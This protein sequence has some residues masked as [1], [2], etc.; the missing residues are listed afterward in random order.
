MPPAASSKSATPVTHPSPSSTTPSTQQPSTLSPT[1][2]P[3]INYHYEKNNA[4]GGI[5]SDKEQLVKSG[6]RLSPQDTMQA[7]ATMGRTHKSNFSVASLLGAHPDSNNPKL[8]SKPHLPDPGSRTSSEGV[9]AGRLNSTQGPH[10]LLSVGG[11]GGAGVGLG[12]LKTLEPSGPTVGLRNSPS[13]ISLKLKMPKFR[14]FG[15]SRISQNARPS[16]SPGPQSPLSIGSP[17]LDARTRLSDDTL[18]LGAME[19]ENN[20]PLSSYLTPNQPPK[21][22]EGTSA[23]W[24]SPPF[25]SASSISQDGSM[26]ETPNTRRSGLFRPGSPGL[27]E[28]AAS[29][30][31]ELNLKYNAFLCDDVPSSV[32]RSAEFLKSRARSF[33]T[34]TQDDM[35]LN[36]QS[37][38]QKRKSLNRTGRRASIST[39]STLLS[40]PIPSHCPDSSSRSDG[41]NNHSRRSLIENAATP[42][43]FGYTR[44]EEPVSPWSPL[45]SRSV[46]DDTA[47][48]P[49]AV[50]HPDTPLTSSMDKDPAHLSSQSKPDSRSASRANSSGATPRNSTPEN[51]SRS[52]GSRQRTKVSP[53]QE[54]QWRKDEVAITRGILEAHDGEACV[55]RFEPKQGWMGYWNRSNME[56]VIYELR[57]LRLPKLQ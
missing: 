30:Q 46:E 36:S 7:I 45:S 41:S 23:T 26:P 17:V 4:Y 1:L 35:S 57:D 11:H 40:S 25:S 2:T 10:A 53:A 50:S 18:A 24:S 31:D 38:A 44:G 34:I 5:L 33:P 56:D 55:I 54:A 42:T 49:T 51:P 29:H 52:E 20:G 43:D 32:I 15:R 3:Q 9:L 16:T 6:Q 8:G 28:F 27:S 19:F 22:E 12:K 21:S 14:S 47:S 39:S 13:S 37:L 48:T